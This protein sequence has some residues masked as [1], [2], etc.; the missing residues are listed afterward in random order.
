VIKTVRVRFGCHEP[1]GGPTTAAA[2]TNTP[3]E[4]Q[5]PKR[6]SSGFDAQLALQVLKL[7]FLYWNVRTD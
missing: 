7:D 1:G 5:R 6:S 2:G 4:Q 3:H